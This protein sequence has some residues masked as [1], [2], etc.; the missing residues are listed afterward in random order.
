VVVRSERVTLTEKRF[1]STAA[2]D[3]ELAALTSLVSETRPFEIQHVLQ[4]IDTTIICASA[5]HLVTLH[6][7]WSGKPP[8]SRLAERVGVALAAVHSV[9]HPDV[10]IASGF[11]FD[12]A[13]VGI[14]VLD[15]SAG[16]REMIRRIQEADLDD[17]FARLTEDLNH[18]EIVFVH[19]DV[20]AANVLVSVRGSDVV[21][22]IDWETSG[23]GSRWLDVGA[24]LAGF[25]ELALVA[26]H[27]PPSPTVLHAL[28]DGY[29]RWMGR[30]ANV[31]LLVRCAG[32][33]M[34]QT[35]V[36]YS[37]SAHIVPV[38]ADRMFVLGKLFL[39]AP[40][41]GAIHLR[42]L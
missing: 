19:G 27:G 32:V 30:A 36:E 29:S 37:A 18:E 21:A 39:R 31:N 11:Q 22:L 7:R 20:R 28:L 8:T 12:P 5:P 17:R 15:A 33:R 4:T 14:G 9:G 16:A 35:A 10:S 40:H 34:L 23:P 13:Q 3:R 42:I 24:A 25:V 6:D 26:G 1:R 41:E 38:V 2:R